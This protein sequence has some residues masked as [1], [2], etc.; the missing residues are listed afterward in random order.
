M[1][2][3]AEYIDVL[4]LFIVEKLLCKI[5][6]VAGAIKTILIKWINFENDF[7]R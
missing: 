1:P 5:V 7:S 6:F 4:I 3:T 2:V